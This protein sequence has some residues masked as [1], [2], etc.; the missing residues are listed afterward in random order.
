MLARLQ[1]GI[2][3]GLLLAACAWWAWQWQ[4]GRPLWALW[5]LLGVL[6]LL[7]GHAIVLALEFVLLASAHGDDP[8][9]RASPRQL[10]AAWWGETLAAP[11]VFCWRQPFRSTLH[12]DSLGA[13]A[14]GRRGVLFVHGFVCNRG[15]WNPWLERLTAQGVPFVALSLEPVFGSIDAYPP[16]I[17]DAVQRLEQATGL[18]PVVVAHSMGGLA[19]RRCLPSARRT[20][21]PGWRALR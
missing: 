18:P 21:A 2:T 6:V 15:L 11:T 12:P 10:V 8:A 9:P 14:K 4:A 17:E 16:A 3:L 20:T 13:S 19:V 1:Q 7:A 5:A